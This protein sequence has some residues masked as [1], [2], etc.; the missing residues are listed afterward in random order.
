MHRLTARAPHAPPHRRA[1]Q[2]PPHRPSS[3]SPASLALTLALA[4]CR[5]APTRD[6]PICPALV[7]AARAVEAD[8]RVLPPDLWF[9]LLIADFDRNTGLAPDD[10]RG[11]SQRQRE[12]VV[13]R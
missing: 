9:R 5:P 4:A 8:S 7:T 12:V 2:A 13:V 6:L 10:P 11:C 3:P 1:P